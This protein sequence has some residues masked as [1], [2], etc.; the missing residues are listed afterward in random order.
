MGDGFWLLASGRRGLAI[1]DCGGKTLDWTAGPRRCVVE[2]AP[3]EA[4]SATGRPL[5]GVADGDGD[6]GDGGGGGG[7]H[8]P[9]ADFVGDLKTLVSVLQPVRRK[10]LDSWP[11]TL[12]RRDRTDRFEVCN[13]D[14]DVADGYDD[15]D[16]KGD[17]DG[18]GVHERTGGFCAV[19]G[20]HVDAP[21][22]ELWGQLKTVSFPL[23]SC[24][25]GEIPRTSLTQR[26][27]G[28]GHDVQP[29][30]TSSPPHRWR[31]G[32]GAVACG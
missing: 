30:P 17:G 15:D 13:G 29:T 14:V 27:C 5:E 12:R 11:T 3:T 10:S 16:G 4:E 1:L 32:T 9:L 8:A 25:R 21:L 31:T 7:V 23:S 19:S 28:H 24:L 22:A 6:G 26:G 20:V 2:T 18:D